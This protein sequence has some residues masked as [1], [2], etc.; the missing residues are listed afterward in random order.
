M[1]SIFPEG[2]TRSK[3]TLPEAL[4]EFS[5]SP[6]KDARQRNRRMETEGREREAEE[7][8][9]DEMNLSPK[10]DFQLGDKRSPSPSPSTDWPRS[11]RLKPS[12]AGSDAEN[13]TAPSFGSFSPRFRFQHS[14]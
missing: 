14:H 4:I 7:V 8:E 9:E 11:K 10:K 5:R 6:F 2:R 12:P 3:S 13:N 1:A